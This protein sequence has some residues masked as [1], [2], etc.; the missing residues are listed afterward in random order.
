M[1]L[2][3][4]NLKRTQMKEPKEYKWSSP[5]LIKKKEKS[6]RKEY[7]YSKGN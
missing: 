1:A 5:E 3:T 7:E 6:Q 4:K 2:N